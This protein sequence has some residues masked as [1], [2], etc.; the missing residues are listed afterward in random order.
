MSNKLLSFIH[1]GSVHIAP[2]TKVLPAETYSTLIN[3]SEVLERVRKDAD[4]YRREVVEEAEKEKEAARREG[5]AAGMEL[6]AAQIALLE[7]EIEDVHADL[8]RLV[9]PLAIKAAKKIVGRELDLNKETRVDIIANA[10]KAISQHQVV[11]I[12]VH[13]TEQEFIDSHREKL[14]AVFDR[15]ESLNVQPREDVEPGGCVVETE[16]GIIH[17]EMDHQW[18]NLEQAIGSFLKKEETADE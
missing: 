18:R 3:A 9:A 14:R 1:D 4:L 2:G 10:L 6:W 11:N 12:F 17:V 5:F 15:L 7:R 16:A 13:P 8:S